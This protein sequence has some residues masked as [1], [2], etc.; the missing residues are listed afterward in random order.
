MKINSPAHRDSQ[1]EL[2]FIPED[3]GIEW[4]FSALVKVHY[5]QYY[6]LFFKKTQT[7]KKAFYKMDRFSFALEKHWKGIKINYPRVSEKCVI[8]QLMEKEAQRG[9]W[10]IKKRGKKKLMNLIIM[11]MRKIHIQGLHFVDH[12][13]LCGTHMSFLSRLSPSYYSSYYF[14]TAF[15]Y[16]PG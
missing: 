12:M 4:W 2:C 8:S 16:F 1:K 5:S 10:K 6:S 15:G 7:L 9:S 11:M 3:K 13:D 14:Y